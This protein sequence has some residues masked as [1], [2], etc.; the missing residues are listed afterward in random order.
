M[1]AG[2]HSEVHIVEIEDIGGDCMLHILENLGR[3]LSGV[4]RVWNGRTESMGDCRE[5][6]RGE[7]I[8]DIVCQPFV[9]RC[10]DVMGEC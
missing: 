9:C 10:I 2:D 3:S 6:Y 8:V 7:K 4:M 1:L 5:K